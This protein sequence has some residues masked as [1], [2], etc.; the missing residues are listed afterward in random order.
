MT[1]APPIGTNTAARRLEK[2]SIRIRAFV[3][4]LPLLVTA[5]GLAFGQVGPPGSGRAVAATCVSCHAAG[6]TMPSLAGRSKSEI[7]ARVQQFRAGKREGTVMPQFAR[8]YTDQQIEQAADWFA[9]Q[10]PSR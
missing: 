3:V 2:N 10:Q 9:A 7:V 4:A 6:G 5:N 8:G 1:A